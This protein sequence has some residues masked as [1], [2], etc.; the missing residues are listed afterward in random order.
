MNAGFS[1]DDNVHRLGDSA[2]HPNELRCDTLTALLLVAGMSPPP[3][4][5]LPARRIAARSGASNCRF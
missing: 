5:A 1:D 3:R 2:T 4:R